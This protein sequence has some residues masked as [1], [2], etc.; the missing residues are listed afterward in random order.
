MAW[1]C[2]M[3]SW[4]IFC[5][6]VDNYGDIGVTWRLSRQLSLEL[7]QRVRLFVDDLNAFRRL[8]PEVDSNLLLQTVFGVEIHLWSGEVEL[9]PAE[10]VIEAFGCDL[11]ATYVDAMSERHPASRW[12]NLEYLSAEA[13]VDGCHLLPSPQLRGPD[14]IFFFPGFSENTGGLLLEQDLMEQRRQFDTSQQ[15]AFLASLG[16][17]VAQNAQ[18]ISLF[19]YENPMI[20]SWLDALQANSEQSCLLVPPGRIDADI[21]RWLGVEQLEAGLVYQRGSLAVQSIP[22]VSQL[23]YDKLLWSCDLNIVRGEDSFV[24]AQWAAKPFIWHIYP[25]EEQVH[26]EKL[27]A[28]LQRYLA[29]LDQEAASAVEQ[30]WLKWNQQQSLTQSWQLWRQQRQVIELHA[31]RWCDELAQAKTLAKSLA[32][33]AQN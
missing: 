20:G 9:Q 28:F 23:E 21:C 31:Q 14:K 5:S 33:F 17:S 25:Q 29:E 6:V 11:P 24:R 30:F 1:V 3:K 2:R 8:C 7:Q 15:Q 32:K 26:L 12:I 18:I 16:V 27:S 13:W 22:F 19:T 10:I 4:D